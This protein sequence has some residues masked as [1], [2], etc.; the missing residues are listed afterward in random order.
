MR[1]VEET[2]KTNKKGDPETVQRRLSGYHNRLGSLIDSY[3]NNSVTTAE[4]D[5]EL[6][7]L[8]ALLRDLREEVS[9]WREKME[10]AAS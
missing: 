8:A 7:D 10:G 9:T 3:I 4:I 2:V 6:E 5:G 1:V